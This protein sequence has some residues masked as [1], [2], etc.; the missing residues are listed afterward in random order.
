VQVRGQSL[1]I[2]ISK[3][4]RAVLDA[5]A[6]PLQ[7]VLIEVFSEQISEIR[8]TN[9][10]KTMSN[11]DINVSLSDADVQKIKDLVGQVRAA[12]P[13]LITLTTKDRMGKQGTGVSL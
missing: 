2:D 5:S 11:P 13:F 6:L 10:R 4:S 8:T 1:H 3:R 9:N 12:M 7:S